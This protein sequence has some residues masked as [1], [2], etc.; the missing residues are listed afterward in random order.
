MAS[1]P[2]VFRAHALRRMFERG[3]SVG[4]VRAVVA[5]GETIEDYPADTPC[6]TR[7]LLGWRGNVPIHVVMARNTDTT[8]FIVI[9]AY[10]PDP[11]R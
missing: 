8:E 11:A 7:L 3:I 1:P 4:D 9:T 6:P 5:Y 2:L 10:I